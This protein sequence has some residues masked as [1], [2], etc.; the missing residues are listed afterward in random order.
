MKRVLLTGATG[1]LGRHCVRALLKRGYEVHA[2][3]STSSTTG[4]AAVWHTCDLLSPEQCK[5][6][7]EQIR[8]THLLHLAWHVPPGKFWRAPENLRWVQASLDLLQAFHT[9]GGKRLVM[10]G[11]C[12]EYA[13]TAQPCIENKTPSAPHS[14]YG[15]CKNSLR[16]ILAS[17]SREFALSSAWA[18]LFFLYGP[19]ESPARLIPYVI[20]CLL[21]D[22]TARCTN[23]NQIRDFIYVEDAADAISALLDCEVNGTVNIGSGVATAVKDLVNMIG[24]KLGC[25]QL[26]QLGA[27]EP[28]RDEVAV[29]L[30]DTGRLTEEI[31][32]TCRSDLSARLDDTINWWLTRPA[33]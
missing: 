7:I 6:L 2:T 19:H 20:N 27:L 21:R 25:E 18:R 29:L 26:V 17:Y 22:Q 14:L 5:G 30:A 28:N 31:G 10:S 16:E 9:V 12:A 13:P 11:T 32:W 24:H 1:F 3:T 8:P 4:Q 33:L 15:V 23:G